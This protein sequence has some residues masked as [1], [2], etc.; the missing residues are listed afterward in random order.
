MSS[1]CLSRFCLS[2][3]CLSR[4]DE[5][6]IGFCWPLAEELQVVT[7]ADEVLSRAGL[8]PPGVVDGLVLIGLVFSDTRVMCVPMTMVLFEPRDPMSM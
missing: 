7:D 4:F 5:T 6:H 2:R 3:F 1:V 8:L